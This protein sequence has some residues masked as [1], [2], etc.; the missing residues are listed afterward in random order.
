[1]FSVEGFIKETPVFR[2]PFW[3]CC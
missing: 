3:A 2:H 1:L